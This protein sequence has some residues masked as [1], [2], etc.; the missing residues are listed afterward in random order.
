[1]TITPCRD[2]ELV[3][4]AKHGCSHARGREHETP[5]VVVV[6]SKIVLERVGTH[7]V[8]A[9]SGESEDDSTR[10]VLAAGYRLEA[11]RHRDVVVRPARREDYV[12]F[13]VGGA[14]HECSLAPRGTRNVLDCPLPGYCLPSIERLG[15]IKNLLSA[16][17]SSNAASDR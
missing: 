4:L 15:E 1:E 10:G 5:A 8:V 12:V 7:Y 13:I 11:D 14:L 9:A 3:P 16:G 17:G 2:L 6:K